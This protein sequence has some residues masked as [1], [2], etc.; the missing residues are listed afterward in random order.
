MKHIYIKMYHQG[1]KDDFHW[2]HLCVVMDNES[3]GLLERMLKTIGYEF[4]IT[5]EKGD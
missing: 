4:K 1:T 2:K 3:L 5:D